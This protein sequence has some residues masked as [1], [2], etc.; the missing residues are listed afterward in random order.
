MDNSIESLDITNLRDG[1]RSGAFSPEDVVE[2]VLARIQAAGDD[3]VWIS[4]A[5]D[6]CVRTTAR[7][8]AQIPQDERDKYPLYGLPFGVKDCIDVAGQP[9]TAACPE[10]AYMPE[11]SSPVV[12]RA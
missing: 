6:E 5:S 10:F 2:Q 11:R 8:L 4:R 12:D 7:K 9:T 3:N 1:Y